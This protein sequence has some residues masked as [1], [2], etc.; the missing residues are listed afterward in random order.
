MP[1]WLVIILGLIVGI[2]VSLI[3]WLIWRNSETS[4][5][6]KTGGERRKHL[7]S[8]V[9]K[10]VT[11]KDKEDLQVSVKL[12]RLT[13]QL[14]GI[15]SSEQPCKAPLIC[16]SGQCQYPENPNTCSQT[17]S[18]I[19]GHVCVSGVC[20]AT[21][22]Q[23]CRNDSNCYSGICSSGGI[24]F[25]G[26]VV[27]W[28]CTKQSWI[29]HS[30]V[31]STIT[32][33]M[34]YNGQLMAISVTGQSA[35]DG[36]YLYRNGS[37]I[38]LYN[39][40]IWND[41][42]KSYRLIDACASTIG[43][44]AV[45]QV[46]D[47]NNSINN[48]GHAIYQVHLNDLQVELRPVNTSNGVQTDCQGKAITIIS[49]D[50]DYT[51]LLLI[52]GTLPGECNQY[53]Y[54]IRLSGISGQPVVMINNGEPICKE[55][56]LSNPVDSCQPKLYQ[57]DIVPDDQRI[58]QVS[59]LRTNDTQRTIQFSGALATAELALQQ[60]WVIDYSLIIPSGQR[61]LLK[62]LIIARDCYN[63]EE[64][65]QAYLI[66]PKRPGALYNIPGY[67]NDDSKICITQQGEIF[68]YCT[69]TCL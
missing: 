41:G 37:W 62:M 3:I 35:T 33:L 5:T 26:K 36:L 67:F 14:G 52:S 31:T 34:D 61:N 9:E 49:I 16:R 42:Q 60:K 13:N 7:Q 22:G 64:P 30:T 63:T 1:T 66:D 32:K 58:H 12:P 39:T 25:K 40:G 38:R 28:D 47:V 23:P 51:G 19:S 65:G 4:T 57:L 10:E 18:C 69:H 53:L 11:V 45:Y 2:V 17:K 27:R 55:V 54:T 24:G 46:I 15:C 68:V 56:S 8:T 21:S 48:V 50:V 29:P 20:L 44:Y 43:I 6:C 59:W